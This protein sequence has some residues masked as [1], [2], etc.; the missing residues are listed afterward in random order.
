MSIIKAFKETKTKMPE[1]IGTS[2][3]LMPNSVLAS[4]KKSDPWIG[5]GP[6][7]V[8]LV[9]AYENV[10]NFYYEGIFKLQDKHGQIMRDEIKEAAPY[11]FT[12]S[13][14][15]EQGEWGNYHM[16]DHITKKNVKGRIRDI[17]G[18]SEGVE[19]ESE[20]SYSGFL[21]YGTATHGV[22]Y[23]FFRPTVERGQREFKSEVITEMRKAI[24]V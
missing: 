11:D 17:P 6:D 12:E 3:K 9:K 16:K 8:R 10:M 13:P 7:A 2:P 19:I 1:L 14:S 15:W 18:E 21:E 23:V 20:A 24:M 5:M 22:Q 4:L